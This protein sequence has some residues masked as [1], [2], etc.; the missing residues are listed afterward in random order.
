MHNLKIST[1]L[2]LLIG[3]LVAMLVAIGLTGL[4]GIPTR[5]VVAS[6]NGE[7]SLF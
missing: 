5:A 4:S 6:D 3:T 2:M 7:W 1:R